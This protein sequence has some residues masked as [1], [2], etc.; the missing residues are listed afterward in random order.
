MPSR[1]LNTKNL[2]AGWA[3][4]AAAI[5]EVAIRTDR[6]VQFAKLRLTLWELNREQ[7]IAYRL[8]GQRVAELALT[9]H[10][11]P[12]SLSA[13]DPELARLTGVIDRLRSRMDHVTQQLAAMDLEGPDEAALSLRRRLQTA[14][15]VEVAAVIGTRSPHANQRLS[16]IQP[17]VECVIMTILRNGVPFVPSGS[18]V[19]QAGDELVLF[20]PAVACETA[21]L[22]LERTTEE[23][24]PQQL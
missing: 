20:G 18:T 17:T 22:F 11:P 21:K 14:G 6:A 23:A 15:L 8:F 3:G 10:Q 16:D 12:E 19:L 9:A 1:L 5:R 4:L 2:K 24:Y 7:L 13:D